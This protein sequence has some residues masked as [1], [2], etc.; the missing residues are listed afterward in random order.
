MGTACGDYN[1]T[2]KLSVAVT[3]FSNE[4]YTLYRNDGGYFTDKS[5][6]AGIA[7]PTLPYLAFGTGFFDSRNSGDLDLFF[8]N[9][10]VSPAA[11]TNFNKDSNY[12]EPNLLML[13]DGA[14]HFSLSKGAL[15]ADDVRVHRGCVFADFNGDGRMDVLVTATDDHP[16]L[17]RNESKSG[18]WLLLRLFDKYGCATPVGARCVA[19]IGA[20][21]LLR[22]VLGGGGYGGDSDKRVHFGLGAARQIDTLEVTWLSGAKQVFHDVAANQSLTLREGGNFSGTG[23]PVSSR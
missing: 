19:T 6:E 20:K 9:G 10:H 1:N 2:G 15:P 7:E 3:T 4:P 21:K 16:S 23:G 22:V 11:K 12:K 18:N 8:A 13:N 14:G 5:A 17:L